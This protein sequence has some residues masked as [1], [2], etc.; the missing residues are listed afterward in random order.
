M[1]MTVTV[2]G[3][4]NAD[5]LVALD[6]IPAP[7]ETV[8]GHDGHI[9]PGGKGANQA[10]AARLAG[11]DTAMVGAVGSDA[12]AEPAL[13]LLRAAGVRL[14]AVTSIEGPTG[15]AVVMTDAA[16]ENSIAVVPGAN[17]S[18]TPELVQAAAADISGA[19]VVVVQGELPPP[20]VTQAA[21]LTRG[22]LLVNLAPVVALDA[23]V[24]RRAD[25]LVVNEHEA[26]G[27]LALLGGAAR[28][29]ERG[30]VQAL[31]D[32]GARSV[33]LT[34]G[35]RGSLLGTADG[36]EQISSPVVEAVDTVGAGD[37]Y[38]GSLAARLASGD[39]LATAA[40]F[41]SRYAAATVTKPGAQPSYPRGDAD[42]PA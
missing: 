37:A 42:L 32:A 25:P 29:D 2:V 1:A 34:V 39:D 10:L 22:R 5:L 38:A 6:S 30:L 9:A 4:I 20:C 40:R 12:F 18:M 8:L 26:A 16:A 19:D 14:D 13:A 31:L 28:E 24:L 35:S 7:G 36:I 41:A 21:E 3:S 23:E 33:V 27:A 17:G 11:A 15:I